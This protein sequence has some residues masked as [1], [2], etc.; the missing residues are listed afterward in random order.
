[1]STSYYVPESS[2]R[3]FSAV[4]ALALLA[5]GAASIL[6]YGWGEV[7]AVIG[8]VAVCLVLFFWFSDVVRESRRGLYDAQMER[9]FR[10]GMAWFI[11]SEMMF[12]AAFFGALFYIRQFALP[13]LDGDGAKGI[14]ALLWPEFSASWPLLT[15][16]GEAFSG[17]KAAIDPWHLPLINTILLLTSSLTLTLAHHALKQG[18]R[19]TLQAWLALTLVL[20]F[21]FLVIQGV[22]YIEAYRHLGL[23]LQ[24]GIYGG[25]FYLL[26]GFHGLHVTIGAIILLVMLLRI[27]RGHFTKQHHFGFAAASWYW[28]FVDAVWVV[29]FVFV[30]V[31]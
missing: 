17:P 24:A 13:W 26:T 27:I 8:G 19:S 30:Y 25:T 7:V 14:S 31:I 11:F 29:L 1:M 9:S 5:I 3:P 22:E 28:H 21:V 20:G 23:T 15:P 12:F 16:P 18:Q 10:Q 2:Y 6:T 4:L